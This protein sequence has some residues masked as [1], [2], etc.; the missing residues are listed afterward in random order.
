MS[1]WIGEIQFDVTRNHFSII[2]KAINLAETSSADLAKGDQFRQSMPALY[3]IK[4]S[5]NWIK[6]ELLPMLIVKL[7]SSKWYFCSV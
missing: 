1:A 4:S 5:T 3:Y 6:K 7:L 2:N